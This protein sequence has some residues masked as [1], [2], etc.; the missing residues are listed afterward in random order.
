MCSSVVCRLSKEFS[1]EIIA[2]K[3]LISINLATS[4]TVTIAVLFVP[5]CIWGNF[6]RQLNVWS[7]NEVLQDHYKIYVTMSISFFIIPSTLIN[8]VCLAI[9]MKL[10]FSSQETY[11][12]S[13]YLFNNEVISGRQSSNGYVEETGIAKP[14][15]S[16]WQ[17]SLQVPENTE[18]FL[19]R[20]DSIEKKWWCKTVN[21]PSR[22]I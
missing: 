15:C 7:L 18:Y 1:S 2:K 12:G 20:R 13:S 11:N 19:R 5:G 16:T 3:G 10:Q 4:W 14:G 9:I 22:I 21:R 17:T 6:R 8:I